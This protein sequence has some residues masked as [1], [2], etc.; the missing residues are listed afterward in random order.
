MRFGFL[1]SGVKESDYGWS[2]N[3]GSDVRKINE[4][5]WGNMRWLYLSTG[6]SWLYNLAPKIKAGPTLSIFVPVGGIL[7][8]H[9]A[10][11]TIISTGIKIN[12]SL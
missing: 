7:S 4:F 6:I 9:N 5:F 3:A 8:D 11:G 10:Q 12:I 1:S 2:G